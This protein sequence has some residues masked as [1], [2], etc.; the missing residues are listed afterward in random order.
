LDALPLCAV[1][2]VLPL[3]KKRGEELEIQGIVNRAKP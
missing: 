3:L 2:G 1:Q